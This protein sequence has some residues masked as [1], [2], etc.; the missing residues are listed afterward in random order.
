MQSYEIENMKP[1][2]E[3]KVSNTAFSN[4]T[5]SM[6]PN[7]TK[8]GENPADIVDSACKRK[9]SER[10]ML[11][12]DLA[13]VGPKKP[14]AMLAPGS[15][16]KSSCINCKKTANPTQLQLVATQLSV[17]VAV[18]VFLG[19]VTIV[20]PIYTFYFTLTRLAPAGPL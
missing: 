6:P 15:G 13:S 7:A 3:N 20:L 5:T 4:P 18:A 2:T 1:K 12:R 14:K 17:A 11:A 19:S 10:S 16:L 9:A 8:P